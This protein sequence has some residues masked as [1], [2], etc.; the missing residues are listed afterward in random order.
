[1][2]DYL[3]NKLKQKELG[4]V[5]QMIEGK[6]EALSTNTSIAKKKKLKYRKLSPVPKFSCAILQ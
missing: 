6:H 2:Q 4:G 1:M 3:K 5:P